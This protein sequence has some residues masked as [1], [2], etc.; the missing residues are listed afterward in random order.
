MK[1]DLRDP[2]AVGNAL[3][4]IRTE[5]PLTPLSKLADKLEVMM[6]P[7]HGE[8]NVDFNRRVVEGS[9]PLAPFKVQNGSGAS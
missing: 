8:S 3:L 1:N 4:S 2:Q 5:F 7:N 6:I 9:L